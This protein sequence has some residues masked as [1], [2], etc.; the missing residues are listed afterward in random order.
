MICTLYAHY[1]IL[2]FTIHIDALLGFLYGRTGK[3]AYFPMKSQIMVYIWQ[4]LENSNIVRHKFVSLGTEY[5][6][7][8][9]LRTLLLHNCKSISR[10]R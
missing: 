6:K 5:D 2:F 9:I 3:S 7:V 10:T 1:F 8:L 4:I